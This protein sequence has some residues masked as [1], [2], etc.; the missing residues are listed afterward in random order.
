MLFL[1]LDFYVEFCFFLF[2]NILS[3]C[4]RG[5]G[6]LWI[7]GEGI[8]GR[9]WFEIEFVVVVFRSGLFING[10]FVVKVFLKFILFWFCF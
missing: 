8:L 1:I 5:G 4:W 6:I 7:Y 2:I 9:L 3:E 10:I